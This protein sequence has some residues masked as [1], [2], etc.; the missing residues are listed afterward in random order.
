[1]AIPLKDI[2]DNPKLLDTLIYGK[3]KC[4]YCKIP[5]RGIYY[6]QKQMSKGLLL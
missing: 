2:I 3:D 4:Y 1:M 6:R 5:L